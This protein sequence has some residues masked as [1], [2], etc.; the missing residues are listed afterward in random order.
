[1]QCKQFHFQVAIELQ[2][3]KEEADFLI[4]R[5]KIHYDAACRA[6]GLSC[7]D[8]APNNGF[9][10]QLRLCPAGPTIWAARQIDM[11]LKI[12]ENCAVLDQGGGMR[13]RLFEELS[14]AFNDVQLKHEEL[15]G[16]R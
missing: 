12:L 16:D 4:E 1:M 5:S 10:A 11:A 3:T 2:F 6:A 15:N 7:D 14:L 9:I 13:A 8:G